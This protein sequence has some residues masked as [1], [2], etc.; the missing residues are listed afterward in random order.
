MEGGT[1]SLSLSLSLWIK[2]KIR[3]RIRVWGRAV[4]L[5]CLYPWKSVVN[6]LFPPPNL[7]RPNA[8][9]H[10]NP[11]PNPNS[12]RRVERS[13]HSLALDA[14]YLIRYAMVSLSLDLDLD[15]DLYTSF[16]MLFYGIALS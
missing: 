5:V 1:N 3:V 9:P 14:L 16:D 12:L 8:N 11:N 15:L 10:P 6:S 4:Q 2:I 13:S 7:F